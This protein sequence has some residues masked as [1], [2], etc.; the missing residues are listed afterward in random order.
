MTFYDMFIYGISFISYS[1]LVCSYTRYKIL[2]WTDKF[3]EPILWLLW[4]FREGFQRPSMTKKFQTEPFPMSVP[5][6]E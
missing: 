4:H 5:D 1:S 3:F 2:D 6:S